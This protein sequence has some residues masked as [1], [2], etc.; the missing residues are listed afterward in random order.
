MDKST[1]AI[2]VVVAFSDKQPQVSLSLP[3]GVT[4]REAV[5]HAEREGLDVGSVGAASAVPIGVF[6]EVV[7]DNYVLM[8]E[9][10]VEIYRP[11]LQSPMELRRQR[12]A[13]Q[14]DR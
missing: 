3:S 13:A 2:R 1:L 12:A 8:D 7:D 6:G 10:R 5:I 11:L 14:K 4:A 9:D